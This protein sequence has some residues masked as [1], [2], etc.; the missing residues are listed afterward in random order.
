MR[1]S[2]RRLSVL[3]ATAAAAAVMLGLTAADAFV[4]VGPRQHHN[5]VTVS[6]NIP[7]SILMASTEESSSPPACAIPSDLGGEDGGDTPTVTVADLRSASLVNQRNERVSLGDLMGS[8]SDDD[9]TSIV[10]FLRHLG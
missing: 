4:V 6:N 8:G 9:K 5:A 3:S 2:S 10:V 1:L 7:S